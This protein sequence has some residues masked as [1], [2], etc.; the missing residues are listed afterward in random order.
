MENENIEQ[1][2][3]EPI[4]TEAQTVVF[5]DNRVQILNVQPIRTVMQTQEDYRQLYNAYGRL[6]EL[7]RK[8]SE[9]SAQTARLLNDWISRAQALEDE[10]K[11]L[12]QLLGKTV[13]TRR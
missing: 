12:R 6:I 7:Y 1:A 13:T 2:R 4:P 9:G 3:V 10:N 8:S 11:M 5:N